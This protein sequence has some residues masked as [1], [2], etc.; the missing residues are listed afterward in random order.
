MSSQLRILTQ[1]V[2]QLSGG[3][4]DID[5]GNNYA[6]DHIIRSAVGQNTQKHVNYL[7]TVPMRLA[8]SGLR[9]GARLYAQIGDT[10]A[11]QL[12]T[13]QILE[14]DPKDVQALAGP[15]WPWRNRGC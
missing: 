12:A 9:S 3:I 13:A 7:L 2:F 5:N 8:R 1:C 4:G 6:I 15:Q 14:H 10:A 11:Q